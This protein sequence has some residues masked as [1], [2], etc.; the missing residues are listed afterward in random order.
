[1]F[2]G[3]SSV[4]QTGLQAGQSV[5]QLHPAL[6]LL[7]RGL[8]PLERANFETPDGSAMGDTSGVGIRTGAGLFRPPPWQEAC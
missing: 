4:K 6:D 1:M 2:Y 8:H 5:L 7:H 3:K